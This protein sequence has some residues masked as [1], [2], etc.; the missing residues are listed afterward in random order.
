M[1]APC[2][3]GAPIDVLWGEHWFFGVCGSNRRQSCG[4]FATLMRY[5]AVGA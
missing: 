2:V 5:E 4:R 1:G 3:A